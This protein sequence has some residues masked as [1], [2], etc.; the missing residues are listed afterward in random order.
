MTNSENFRTATTLLKKD[1]D[2]DE[3]RPKS[4]FYSP[5]WDVGSIYKLGTW[6]YATNS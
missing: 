2:D 5:V 4:C 6:T 1:R 3:G